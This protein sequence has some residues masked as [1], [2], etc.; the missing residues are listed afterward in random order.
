M[1]K[2]RN[3][4]EGYHPLVAL[5]GRSW[6]PSMLFLKYSLSLAF[7]I[8]KPVEKVVQTDE[9]VNILMSS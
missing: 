5:R 2:D 7:L 6:L 1:G 3:V 9:Q 4:R 8:E